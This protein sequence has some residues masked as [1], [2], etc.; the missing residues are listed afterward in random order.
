LQIV[1]KEYLLKYKEAKA[2]EGNSPR[3]SEN[4]ISCHNGNEDASKEGLKLNSLL[5]L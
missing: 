1:L 4:A 2:S 3:M 5:T